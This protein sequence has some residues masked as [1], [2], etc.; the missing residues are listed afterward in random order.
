MSLLRK[1]RR[2]IHGL[3]AD[4][5][6]ADASGDGHGQPETIA[7]HLARAGMSAEA[8]PYWLDAAR[9]ARSQSA[10]HEAIG[11]L[12]SG[13]A[14]LSDLPEDE[15]RKTVELDFQAMLAPLFLLTVGWASLDGAAAFERSLAL[16]EEI[17]DQAHL[18]YVLAGLSNAIRWHGKTDEAKRLVDR[19]FNLAKT[20]G[21]PDHL[22][23]AHAM[24]GQN[25]MFEGRMRDALGHYEEALK[26]HRPSEH[27]DLSLICGFDPAVLAMSLAAYMK[28]HL[29]YPDQASALARQ[30]IKMAEALLS[31]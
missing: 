4:T 6:K 12:R 16:C 1:N 31:A 23:L 18:P 17:N 5:L 15:W 19:L 24:H 29:G 9:K 30:A 21:E 2:K 8:L 27:R 10:S 14:L 13:L 3:I 26:Y 28:W 11:H 25:L 22:L 20:T 7:R